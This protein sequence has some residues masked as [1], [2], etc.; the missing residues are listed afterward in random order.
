MLAW[1][2][3]AYYSAA[4]NSIQLGFDPGRTGT[5]VSDAASTRGHGAQTVPLPSR[6]FPTRLEL[7]KKAPQSIPPPFRWYSSWASLRSWWTAPL[8]FA[9]PTGHGCAEKLPDPGL[10]VRAGPVGAVTYWNA[11]WIRPRAAQ[12]YFARSDFGRAVG[13]IWRLASRLSRDAGRNVGVSAVADEPSP[14]KILE[15]YLV[16]P[17]VA[18]FLL[19]AGISARSMCRARSMW[20][21]LRKADR[22]VALR[23]SCSSCIPWHCCR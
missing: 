5:H 3:F 22:R 2:V 4:G 14:Q 1:K 9:G 23:R 10:F 21:A 16:T 6:C 15:A 12:A 20:S 17:I 18:L 13:R 11:F 7:W 19:A 8:I